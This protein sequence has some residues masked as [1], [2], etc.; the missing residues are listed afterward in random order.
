MDPGTIVAIGIFVV[1][2]YFFSQREKARNRVRA[3]A[4]S[5]MAQRTGLV[6]QENAKA[7]KEV[8]VLEGRYRGRPLKCSYT[9]AEGYDPDETDIAVSVNTRPNYVLALSHQGLFKQRSWSQVL[10]RIPRVTKIDAA[11]E[12]KFTVDFQ[13]AELGPMFFDWPGIRRR[14]MEF[15]SPVEISLY[16][17]R[18]SSSLSGIDD[19]KEIQS[20]FELLSDIA[21]ALEGLS[22][23]GDA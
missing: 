6:L 21:D 7:K 12:A 15:E 23:K 22:G 5:E 8:L 17:R 16:H 19:L 14:L 10:R 3:L 2:L 20:Y 18:L 11:L 13:P 1:V 4:W 9:P